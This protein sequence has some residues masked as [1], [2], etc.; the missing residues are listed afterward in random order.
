MSNQIVTT[1]F[2]TEW[3]LLDPVL[4]IR[5]LSG[6]DLRGLMGFDHVAMFYGSPP[7]ANFAPRLADQGEVLP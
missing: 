1:P 7:C 3:E 4:E 5:P 6:D 2:A